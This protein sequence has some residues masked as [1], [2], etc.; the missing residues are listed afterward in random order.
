MIGIICWAQQEGLG[1]K[2]RFGSH[3]QQNV[4]AGE[5]IKGKKQKAQEIGPWRSFTPR[6]QR[7]RQN[8]GNK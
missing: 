3:Q 7:K 6:R 5:Y 1:W 4:G 8:L 2:Y